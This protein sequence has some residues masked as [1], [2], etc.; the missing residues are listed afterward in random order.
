MTIYHYHHETGEY[1]GTGTADESPKEPG[2]YLIPAFATEEVPPEIPDGKRAVFVG[3]HWTLEDIPTP[4][5]E[6]EPEP[7]PEP[8]M[9]MERFAEMQG[10]RAFDLLNLSDV[11]RELEKQ[12]IP[13]PT[14]SAAVRQWVNDVRSAFLTGATPPA[15]PHTLTEVLEEIA[16]LQS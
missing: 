4:E 11:E 8:P 3:D 2:V 16:N 1:L 13:L 12:S 9:T 5:P 6:L 15:A 14:K 10:F 7:E